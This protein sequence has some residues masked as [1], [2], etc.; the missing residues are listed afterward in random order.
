MDLNLIAESLMVLETIDADHLSYIEKHHQLPPEVISEKTKHNSVNSSN[1]PK[2]QSKG[3]LKHHNQNI[4]ESEET[5]FVE[6][7][8]NPS[9]QSETTKKDSPD[10]K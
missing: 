9:K 3:N 6:P 8:A 1:E 2:S 7:E 10:Q 4:A 5:I